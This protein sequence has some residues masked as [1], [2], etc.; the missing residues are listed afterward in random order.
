MRA[1]RRQPLAVSAFALLAGMVAVAGNARGSESW[2][3]GAEEPTAHEFQLARSMFEFARAHQLSRGPSA[4]PVPPALDAYGPRVVVEDGPTL[5]ARVTGRRPAGPEQGAALPAAEQLLLRGI[6]AG[7]ARLTSGFG[8]CPCATAANCS[9]HVFCNGAEE[10]LESYCARGP[11]PCVD[12]DA[13]T[14][15]ECLEGLSSCIFNPIPPPAEVGHLDVALAAP[16]SAVAELHWTGVSGAT[17]YN[18]YRGTKLNL[19]DL[20][21]FV[22]HTTDTHAAD[23]V[24][25][26]KAYFYL[27]TAFACGE[28]TLGSASPG[29]RPPP[30]GCP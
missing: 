12:G 13:C 11:A 15:D 16:G 4:S 9:D 26:S 3:R 6:A 18:V 19:A 8:C 5:L 27:V 21:C 30:P 2:E 25:P 7:Y 1:R 29:T 14:T 24:L 28:S 10:C 22:S 20:A 17:N 23:G